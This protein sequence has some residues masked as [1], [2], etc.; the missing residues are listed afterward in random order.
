MRSTRARCTSGRSALPDG[1][2]SCFTLIESV[3]L[4]HITLSCWPRRPL[5]D[6]ELRER[7]S[8]FSGTLHDGGHVPDDGVGDGQAPQLQEGV[9][10]VSEGPQEHPALPHLTTQASRASCERNQKFAKFARADTCAWQMSDYTFPISGCDSPIE[11]R[12][13]CCFSFCFRLIL[14][15]FANQFSLIALHCNYS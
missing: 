9:R 12:R 2:H 4:P 15:S 7:S 11:T 13:R 6:V 10:E 8:V 1:R 5:C 14:Q 3:S